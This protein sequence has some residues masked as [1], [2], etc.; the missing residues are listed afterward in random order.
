MRARPATLRRR[1]W[2]RSRRNRVAEQVVASTGRRRATIVLGVRSARRPT[3]RGAAEYRATSAR[4]PG[5]VRRVDARAPMRTA[6]RT[7][8]RAGGS[9][10]RLRCSQLAR[11]TAETGSDHNVMPKPPR[12]QSDSSFR[13]SRS[14]QR[15]YRHRRAR[16]TEPTFLTSG[17]STSGTGMVSV[18]PV[19]VRWQAHC[20]CG[21][22]TARL[23]LLKGIAVND[24]HEHAYRTGCTVRWP[25]VVARGLRTTGSLR[26][27]QGR[28][29]MNDCYPAE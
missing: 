29:S 1:R 24:A 27:S 11:L 7:Q 16:M 25:L 18:M 9:Q 21:E 28:P 17:T 10:V 15:G 3:V 20:T 26:D 8:A 23:H 2:R 6:R 14:D 19:G 4:T 22:M 5:A 12:W 13:R